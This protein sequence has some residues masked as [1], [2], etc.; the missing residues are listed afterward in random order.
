MKETKENNIHSET[1]IHRTWNQTE[2][3]F[4]Y[5]FV[6]AFQTKATYLEFRRCWKQSYA[7]LAES[8]RGL[9]S[10]IKALMRQREYA[11]QHQSDLE[12][13]KRV[14]T[15]QLAMLRAAKH[16]AN[17]QYLAAKAVGH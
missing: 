3:R 6:F 11:G 13:C 4:D 14:A 9:K 7:A 10:S 15:V 2:N 16:E 5:S 8:I 1:I 17:R 12:A